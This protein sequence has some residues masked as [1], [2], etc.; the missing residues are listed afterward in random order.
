[1]CFKFFYEFDKVL[2][3][4][5]NHQRG[6][7]DEPENEP[8]NVLVRELEQKVAE[9]VAKGAPEELVKH[10]SRKKQLKML[11][12]DDPDVLSLKKHAMATRSQT[13]ANLKNLSTES[14]EKD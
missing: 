1:M 12:I 3:K 11:P 13:K 14:F 4:H 6:F 9:K 8:D 7:P 10:I 5:L 2:K